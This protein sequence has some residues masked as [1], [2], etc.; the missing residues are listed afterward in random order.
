MDEEKLLQAV[1]FCFDAVVEPDAWPL[2]LQRFAEAAGATSAMFYP[3][4]VNEN[5]T[6]VPASEGYTEFLEH[7]VAG[8]WYERHY[9][10]ERGWPLL[11]S[12]P[13]TAVTEHDLA[14]EEERKRLAHYNELYMRWG[15]PGFLAVGFQI[16]GRAWC[17]PLLR[18]TK[19]GHFSREEANKLLLLAPYLRRMVHLSEQFSRIRAVSGLDMLDVIDRPSI[20]IGWQGRVEVMNGKAEALLARCADT[21]FISRGGYLHAVHPES[22]ERLQR[23]LG[24]GSVNA[25]ERRQREAFRIRIERP[26]SGR[27]LIVEAVSQPGLVAPV[28]AIARTV[29]LLNDLEQRQVPP[30]EALK[31]LLRLT[32]AEARLCVLMSSGLSLAEAGERLAITEG[33]AR[34]RLKSI[35][36]KTDTK[37]Q[38]ELIALLLKLAP[39]LEQP[40]GR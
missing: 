36:H 2:A 16:E 29:L 25:Q 15:Y 30:E 11:N 3:K 35:F 31:D 40:P 21:L 32:E 27:P 33:T 8:K 28:S 17:M 7:Y 38:S 13:F 1:D 34:Q 9:R 24:S 22:E 39:R 6:R 10:A 5:A 14:T 20:V 4:D 12:R 18:N 23:L 19:Q 37:R 26:L